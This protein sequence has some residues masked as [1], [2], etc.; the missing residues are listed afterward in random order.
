MNRT[1]EFG[2]KK[3]VLTILYYV[4]AGLALPRGLCTG[5]NV[6]GIL[7]WFRCTCAVR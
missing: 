4:G 2:V 5:E 7:R 3:N 1:D 6:A